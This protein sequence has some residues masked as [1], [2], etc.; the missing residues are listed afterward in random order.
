MKAVMKMITFFVCVIVRIRVSSRDL[1]A[2]RHGARE[3][4]V[5]RFFAGGNTVV[6]CTWV[7][8]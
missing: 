5:Y 8:W 6:D 1:L 7:R 2:V 4:L 3:E